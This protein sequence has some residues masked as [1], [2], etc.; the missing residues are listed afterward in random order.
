MLMGFDSWVDWRCFGLVDDLY[1][2]GRSQ[3]I[4]LLG[5]CGFPSDHTGENR[6]LTWPLKCPS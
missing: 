4:E 6:A 5:T 3:F 1:W 2:L